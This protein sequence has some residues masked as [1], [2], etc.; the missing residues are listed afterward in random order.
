MPV[1]R[2]LSDQISRMM[3]FEFSTFGESDKG[4]RRLLAWLR[5]KYQQKAD[6]DARLSVARDISEGIYL[7][8]SIDNFID[9]HASREHVA[10]VGKLAI[11]VAISRAEAGCSL[12]VSSRNDRNR[13]QLDREGIGDTWIDSFTRILFDRVRADNVD[14]VADNVTIVSFNYDRCL[15]Q[16]LVDALSQT[17]RLT[18]ADAH[19]IVSRIRIIHPYGSLGRLPAGRFHA[20]G[21]DEV[22]FGSTIEWWARLRPMVIS[23]KDPHLYRADRGRG[24]PRSDPGRNGASRESDLLGVRF[25]FPEHGPS[26]G[27]QRGARKENLRNWTRDRTA[28]DGRIATTHPAEL[29]RRSSV[30][31]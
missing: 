2:Q 25:P 6:L 21:P 31:Y 29:C 16:Y 14:Q 26:H 4:D 12:F 18:Y 24:G 7:A 19:Q 10:E 15:E 13:L 17:Y 27:G 1:G 8:S 20:R 23:S 22:A 28:G 9:M 3:F 30:A 5:Q 11:A